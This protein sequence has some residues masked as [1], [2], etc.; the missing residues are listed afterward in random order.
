[1]NDASK[2]INKAIFSGL[3]NIETI[4]RLVGGKFG[5]AIHRFPIKGGISRK[6]LIMK[7]VLKHN[8]IIE[9]IRNNRF[10]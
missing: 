10:I 2:L 3:K 6:D 8:K 4:E 5:F 7:N 1:M 9:A